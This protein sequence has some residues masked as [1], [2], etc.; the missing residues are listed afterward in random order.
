MGRTKKY[1]EEELKER[2]K[3]AYKHWKESE[4]GSKMYRAKYLLYNYKKED[5]LYGR[6]LPDFD[7]KWIVENIFTKPCKCGESDWHKLGCD[8]IDNSIGHIKSNVVS[9]CLHCN[10]IKPKEDKWKAKY[11]R[12]KYKQVDQINPIDG[13]IVK[14]WESPTHCKTFGFN[15]TDIQQCCSNKRKTH[16][17]YIWKYVP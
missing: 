8:R 12:N 17:G 2:K 11:S 10:M 9:S 15:R 6:E 13:E 1:T 16:K 14:T 5:K 4:N 3:I 7:S